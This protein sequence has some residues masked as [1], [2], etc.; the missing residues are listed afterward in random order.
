MRHALIF[1]ITHRYRAQRVGL[2]RFKVGMR[3]V[4]SLAHYITENGRRQE[5]PAAA[6]RQIRTKPRG[7]DVYDAGHH[8]R[9]HLRVWILL[10]DKSALSSE[11]I[12]SVALVSSEGRYRRICKYALRCVPHMQRKKH[13]RPYQKPKVVFGISGFDGLHGIR[14]IA[15]SAAA[16]LDIAHLGLVSESKLFSR[17]TG[18]P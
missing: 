10:F 15:F 4:K 6:V 3:T 18:H 8:K 5:F 1:K 13:I 7:G 12:F 17:E 9:K 14:G 16:Y 2:K 11:N